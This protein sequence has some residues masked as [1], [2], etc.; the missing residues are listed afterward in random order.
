MLLSIFG[1]WNQTRAT[2]TARSTA[3]TTLRNERRLCRDSLNVRT[4]STRNCQY[5]RVAHLRSWG[6]CLPSPSLL[7]V[8]TVSLLFSDEPN[9]LSGR[10]KWFTVLLDEITATSGFKGSS[11]DTVGGRDNRGLDAYSS[12]LTST[13]ACI[14]TSSIAGGRG[15]G[16]RL[17]SF[18]HHFL[19]ENKYKYNIIRA[20][21]CAHLMTGLSSCLG[22]SPMSTLRLLST[23]TNSTAW[24]ITIIKAIVQWDGIYS[25]R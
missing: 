13:S 17:N 14:S 19:W 15:W 25:R 23:L 5:H 12:I 22:S 9:P 10:A 20:V 24:E 16:E 6:M 1:T 7:W 4:M 3:C 11:T 21:G 18:C 8:D 2:T